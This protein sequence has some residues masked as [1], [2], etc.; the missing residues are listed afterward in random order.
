MTISMTQGCDYELTTANRIARTNTAA[1]IGRTVR[2]MT[3]GH[4]YLIITQGTGASTMINLTSSQ[5]GEIPIGLHSF[6]EVD[7]NGDVANAAGNGG[8]LASDTTPIMRADAAESLEIAWATGNVDS[9]ATQFALP[10]DFDGSR[11]CYLDLI[12]YSGTTDAATFTVETSWDGGALVSDS[13]ADTSTKSATAHTITATISAADVGDTAARVT[14]ALTPT[15]AHATDAYALV[16]A[17]FRYF[18]E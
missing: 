15:N 10:L 7:G 5:Y 3:N 14:I 1:D 16:G 13:A 6:R 2:D 11:D 8:I 4:I 12:V 17:R 18:R 9:I